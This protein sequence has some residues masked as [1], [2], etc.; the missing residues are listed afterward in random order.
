MPVSSCRKCGAQIHHWWQTCPGCGTQ[1]P[2]I[3]SITIGFVG[4]TILLVSASFSRT[5]YRHFYPPIATDDGFRHV[6]IELITKNLQGQ[7]SF[8]PPAE[9]T[10][11]RRAP[12]TCLMRSW[13]ESPDGSGGQSRVHFTIVIEHSGKDYWGLKYLKFDESDRVI[14]QLE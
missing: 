2:I 4:A 3:G 11:E 1:W 13:A 5:V 6:A 8:A 10:F 9:W 7:H 12:N 14:G